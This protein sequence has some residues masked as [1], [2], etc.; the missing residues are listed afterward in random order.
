MSPPP[1][2]CTPRCR[3]AQHAAEVMAALT[4]ADS[5]GRLRAFLSAHCHNAATL[6]DAFGR[7]ALHMAASLGRRPLVEWL[8]QNKGADLLV[9]DKESGWTALHRSTF[10]GHIHCLLA[11]V[12]V[13]AARGVCL[14]VIQL[15]SACVLASHWLIHNQGLPQTVHL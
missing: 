6:R 9:K 15:V 13:L 4:A 5:E 11:L 12:K 10:Y 14:L 2:D 8:L 3:S 1:S 7:T